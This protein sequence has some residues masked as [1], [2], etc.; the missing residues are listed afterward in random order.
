MQKKITAAMLV[1]LL[2]LS[3]CKSLF[4]KEEGDGSG[5]L[6]TYT[7]TENPDSLDPQIAT[8]SA[9]FTV[10]RN[11]MQGLLEEQPD[12][13]ITNGVA[14]SYTV[15]E[16]G[17]RYTFTLRNDSYWYYDENK[18]DKID[19]G[20]SWLV[21]A[22]DFVFAFQRLFRSETKSPYREEFRSIEGADE[23]IDKGAP[24]T[25]LAVYA[26]NANT[27]VI[28]LDE[29]CA[30]FLTLLC[31]PAAMPCSRAFFEETGGKYGLDEN[32]VIS[33]SGF[34]IRRWF[35][36]PYG[37][38][39][40]IYMQRN[41][42]NDAA[43]RV[44]PSDVTFLIRNSQTQAEEAFKSGKSDV[45][46][47]AVLDSSYTAENGYSVSSWKSVSLGFVLN[48]QWEAFGN[49]DIRRAFSV[50]IPRKLFPKSNEADVQGAYEIVP[51]ET[52]IGSSLYSS[53]ITD[54][55]II[56]EPQE[57]AAELFKKGMY[58]LGLTSLPTADVLVC[59]NTIAED[60]LYEVIQTWQLQFGFYAGLDIVPQSE[61]NK[62]LQSGDYVI[63]L[64][65]VEGNRNSAEAVLRSFGTGNNSFGYSNKNVDSL[66]K[67]AQNARDSSELAAICRQIESAVINDY[68]YL[69]VFHKNRYLV[70][71]TGNQDISFDPYSGVVDFRR[72]KYYE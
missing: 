45:L 70:Y 63:A 24:V 46:A 31:M 29:V 23:I 48:T 27:L 7:L 9:A 17:L 16:D 64:C 15:T 62:R 42:A 11:M 51:P 49:A 12:G 71:S 38:D 53:Y 3:G 2:M 69:P 20:E 65:S 52:R 5:Y 56:D 67:A 44:Y 41:S 14:S 25:D 21:T 6:F 35:Y 1:P 32:S 28:Q 50:S 54:T 72:A 22:E 36:D 61:Y 13:T 58:E 66:L 55:I 68:V 10:L 47:T 4:A 43:Q 39:N 30:D 26:E 59:E 18:N 33:N 37:K 57:T 8:N 34:Y 19:D 60:A 40:L